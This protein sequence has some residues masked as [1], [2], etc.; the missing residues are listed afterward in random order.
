MITCM[1]EV[2][3]FEYSFLMK[4]ER[5][6]ERLIKQK[7]ASECVATHLMDLF[8]ELSNLKAESLANAYHR[9]ATEHQRLALHY[10]RE[11]K[12]V[13]NQIRYQ[14]DSYRRDCPPVVPLNEDLSN[15]FQINRK[16]LL[17]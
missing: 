7:E 15:V 11:I 6:L 9:D 8:L 12:D 14:I 13:K 3:E 10:G 4:I 1:S 17:C 2:T 5:K 16:I